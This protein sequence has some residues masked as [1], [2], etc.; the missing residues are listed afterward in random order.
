[1]VGII[2]GYLRWALPLLAAG[3]HRDLVTRKRSRGAGNAA[4]AHR[5]RHGAQP[6]RSTRQAAET[7]VRRPSSREREEASLLGTFLGARRRGHAWTV[8]LG[9][10]LQICASCL[11][12][13]VFF[14]IPACS[15][16][17]TR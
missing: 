12:G 17:R 6:R 9:V 4:Q 7:G 3:R 15:A 5:Q 13:V 2:A 16:W 8:V 14:V 1:M 11:T 10:A